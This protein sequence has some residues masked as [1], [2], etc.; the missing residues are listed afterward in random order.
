LKSSPNPICL[1]EE[2]RQYIEKLRAIILN[3]GV[4]DCKMEE[5]SLRCERQHIDPGP[6][7][8]E[9]FGTKTEIKKPQLFQIL[10]RSLSL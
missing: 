6:V 1:T 8:A 5:G 7:G 2:A 4:S 3:T 9:W 10:Q